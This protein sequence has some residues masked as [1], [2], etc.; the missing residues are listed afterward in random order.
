VRIYRTG[1]AGD[2]DQSI[3]RNLQIDVLEIVNPRA[4]DDDVT[5]H[6]ESLSGFFMR[7]T[8]DTLSIEV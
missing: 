3:A 4:F 8:D 7:E 2:D 5:R 6:R 1:D